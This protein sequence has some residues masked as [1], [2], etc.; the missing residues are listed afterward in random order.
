MAQVCTTTESRGRSPC[1]DLPSARSEFTFTPFRRPHGVLSS[2]PVNPLG[3]GLL[4]FAI[5][6]SV[7]YGV[8]DLP[9]LVA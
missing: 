2:R 9:G 6:G 5:S 3:A 8:V 1:R 4:L 7:P